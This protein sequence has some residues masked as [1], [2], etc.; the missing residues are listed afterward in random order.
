MYLRHKRVRKNGKVHTYWSLV[1]SVRV[2]RKVRQEVVAQLGKLNAKE[3]ARA[4]VFAD[5]ITGRRSHPSLFEPPDVGG[6]EAAEINLK[7]ITL[8]RSRRFGDVF[9][10]LVLWRALGLD[11]LLDRLM[12]QGREDIRWSTVAAIHAIL[13]LC[14]PSSDLFLAESLYPK[15]ALEDLLGVSAEKL[16]EDRVYRALDELLPH[17]EA[18]EKHLRDRLGTLFDLDYDILL[19][20]VTSTYFEGLALRNPQARRGY[21]RDHRPDCKQV[22]VALVVTR[23]GVPLAYEVFDGNRVDVTTVKEI[24]TTMESRFGAANRVWV[25]DRGMASEANVTF[26][27]KGGRRYLIGARKSDLKRYEGQIAKE[28]DWTRI[29]DDIE[30]KLCPT[31][32]GQELY[33]LCRSEQ[34]REKDR[35]IIDRF[36][37]R[38]DER[39]E[40]LKR[41]IA[42]ATKP[43]DRAQVDQQ[44][45]RMLQSNVRAS[46]KYDLRTED[47]PETPAGL[48][49]I[50]DENPSWKVTRET[51]AGCY[52]L[53]TNITAWTHDELW[54]TYIQL[55][56]AE[57]AF[58]T[59]KSQ[60]SIRPVWH[61]REDRT[62]AH[63][64]VCFIAYAMWKTLELWQE[65][66]RLGNSPRMVLDELR[67]IQSAD[68]VLPTTDGRVLKVRCVV[69]PEPAQ[70]VLLERLGLKLPRRLRVRT[71]LPSC[72]M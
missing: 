19:Y 16:N 68:V 49:L 13:R 38:L 31:E 41:R 30:V 71:A 10:G 29:R 7:G 32:D 44:I 56:D 59:H 51:M 58:R 64:F 2:G 69:K 5:H 27:R 23:G 6:D 4:E 12:P 18:V 3:R 15:T 21:S 9:L 55:T 65:R 63:I 39:V 14:E 48:R 70:A 54:R 34:R 8:E 33:I 50:A 35:A 60:L 61:H 37:R 1:R 45:G 53:R 36:E 57:D 47:A 17:K 40:S 66:A 43:L 46:G 52:L 11:E 62:K 42:K 72:K 67:E 24:V 25:M 22:C 28:R 20:D 26:L